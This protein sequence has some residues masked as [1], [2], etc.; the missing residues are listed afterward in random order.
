MEVLSACLPTMAPFLTMRDHWSNIRSA[1]RSLLP[2]SRQKSKT[3]SNLG[4]GF[5]NPFGQQQGVELKS[6][7]TARHSDEQKSESDYVPLRSIKMRHDLD[8]M[9]EGV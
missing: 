2:S 5:D 7:I 9:E 4:R 1:F 6:E 8:Q 3:N